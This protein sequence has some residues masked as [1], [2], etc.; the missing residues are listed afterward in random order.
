MGSVRGAATRPW[1]TTTAP[2]S[3][4][5][6]RSRCE[7]ELDAQEKSDARLADAAAT[8]REEL[9]NQTEEAKARHLKSLKA[10]Y[11]RAVAALQ[12]Y[13]MTS[14]AEAVRAMEMVIKLERLIIGEPSER[15][16]LSVEDVTKREMDR[17]ITLAE[18]RESSDGSGAE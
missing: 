16:E 3:G 7:I 13:P 14:A 6:R 1:R 12:K 15:T 17:W 8:R 11:F 4:R 10:V 9:A 18:K 5:S 2:P